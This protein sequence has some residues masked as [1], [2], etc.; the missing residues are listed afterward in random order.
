MAEN[1]TALSLYV[2]A[3]MDDALSPEAWF[4]L[5][6]N[7]GINNTTE[8]EAHT[9]FYQYVNVGFSTIDPNDFVMVPGPMSLGSTRL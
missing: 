7:A 1:V 4:A 5:Y 6:V 2:N 8:D 9:F 3:G